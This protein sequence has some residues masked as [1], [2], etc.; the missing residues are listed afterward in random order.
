M[1]C[2]RVEPWITGWS[3]I[4]FSDVGTVKQPHLSYRHC[5]EE[6]VVEIVHEGLTFCW[7]A[8]HA[9]APTCGVEASEI[10]ISH[11]GCF[12]APQETKVEP[13]TKIDGC[14]P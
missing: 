13:E 4:K 7:C 14:F 9:A 5:P 6:A 2:S 12:A 1:R 10:P 11:S 8:V 3:W